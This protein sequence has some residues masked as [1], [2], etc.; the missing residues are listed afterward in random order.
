MDVWATHKRRDT[1]QVAS[2]TMLAV[3]MKVLDIATK[4]RH[5]RMQPYVSASFILLIVAISMVTATQLR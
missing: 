5:F 4:V 2:Q 1:T 3:C